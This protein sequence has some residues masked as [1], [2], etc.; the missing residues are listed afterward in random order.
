M[1]RGMSDHAIP[2]L[3]LERSVVAGR[4]VPPYTQAKASAGNGGAF[5]FAV[6]RPDLRC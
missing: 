5:L 2:E 1:M 4:I 6:M 3:K